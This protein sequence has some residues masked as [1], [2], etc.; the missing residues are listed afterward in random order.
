[1][2]ARGRNTAMQWVCR[3]TTPPARS[4]RRSKLCVSSWGEPIRRLALC[5]VWIRH[6]DFWLMYQCALVPPGG[7]L[8]GRAIRVA[9]D[10]GG[11][12]RRI[13]ELESALRADYR[14][15]AGHLVTALSGI[16]RRLAAPAGC[17]DRYCRLA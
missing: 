8:T 2:T 17:T 9:G 10:G 5:V 6:G 3:S 16:R 12:R 4:G 7:G 1:M 11:I 15:R 14:H 13:S